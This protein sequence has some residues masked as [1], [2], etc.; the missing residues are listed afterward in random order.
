MTAHPKKTPIILLASDDSCVM[1]NPKLM[2]PSDMNCANLKCIIRKKIGI[3]DKHKALFIY[4]LHNKLVSDQTT[5]KDLVAK[6]NCNGILYL[7]VSS[8]EVFG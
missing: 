3:S 4:T 8:E 1:P 7:K 5:I 6:T 2:F